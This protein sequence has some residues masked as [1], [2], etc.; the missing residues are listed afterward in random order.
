[1]A[2]INGGQV[3]ARQLKQAGIDTAFG[4]VAGPMIEV[5]AGMLAALGGIV[6]LGFWAAARLGFPARDIVS[7]AGHDA[8][9]VS[10]VVPTA[11]I[12]TPCFS[13]RASRAG[14]CS[15]KCW[16][17]VCAQCNCKESN[18]L[19]ESENKVWTGRR[20]QDSGVPERMGSVMK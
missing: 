7:G 18:S 5:M 19:F 4:V 1:M 3:V 14:M 13:A 20:V 2:E 10:R 17:R 16:K 12:F 11:M 6:A 8:V 15:C 9:Y